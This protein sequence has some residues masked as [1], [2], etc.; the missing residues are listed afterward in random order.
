MSSSLKKEVLRF[1]DEAGLNSGKVVIL[2]QRLSAKLEEISGDSPSLVKT[3]SIL[4]QL[5][6]AEL[7]SRKSKATS[8]SLIS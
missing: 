4:H 2:E 8:Q 1:Y 3:L 5:L 6:T 7:Q